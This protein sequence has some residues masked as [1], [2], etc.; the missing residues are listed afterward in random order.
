MKL[1]IAWIFDH[2]GIDWRSID[3][4]S[5]IEKFNATT[6]EIE[7]IIPI[8]LP[9]SEVFCGRVQ[10]IKAES[11]IVCY[12]PEIDQEIMLPLRPDVRHEQWFLVRRT[13][14]GFAWASGNDFF[15]AKDFLI[16]AV[17][18]SKD[19]ERGG[20]RAL[21]EDT[22]Y[23][24]EVGNTSLTNRSDMW[25]HRGFAREIG[26]ILG[27]PLI[28]LD[29]LVAKVPLVQASPSFSVITPDIQTNQCSRLA[30]LAIKSIV[31]QPTAIWM[32]LCLLRLD[33]R[34]HNAIVDMTNYVMF[35]LGHPMH[36]FDAAKISDA[37]LNVR[38]AHVG[39]SLRILDGQLIQLDE[40]DLVVADDKKILSLAGII[41]GLET[42]ISETTKSIVL[43]AACFDAATI[44][45]SSA[46]HKKRTESSLRFEKTLDPH[47]VVQAIQRFVALM[48]KVGLS[49]DGELAIM[50][51]GQLPEPLYLEITHAVIE[52]SLG[53]S[54]SAAFVRATFKA[55]ECEVKVLDDDALLPVYRVL[56][57]SFRATKDLI[58]TADLI[59]EVSR[60]YGYDAIHAVLPKI[61][62][63]VQDGRYLRMVRSI[64]RLL[65]HGLHMRELQSYAFFD[66]QFLRVI[67]FEPMNTVAVQQP[68]SEH[69][70]RLVTSLVPHLLHAV[71]QGNADHETLRF[72][73]WNR[74][75]HYE[76]EL[77][78]RPALSGI[79]FQK[80]IPLDFYA[81]KAL[82]QPLFNMIDVQVEWR[83][84]ETPLWPWLAPYQS[85]RLYAAGQEI[86]YAGMVDEM[87]FRP[88]G[89]GQ[90]FVFE[91]DVD[92]FCALTGN[93]KQFVPLARYP[94][95]TRDISMIMPLTVTT[96]EIES[97]IRLL[98][99]RIVEVL[100]VDFYQQESW[101]D[102]RSFT[103]RVIMK[104]KNAT[105]TAAEIDQL[106]ELVVAALVS[107]GAVI[108]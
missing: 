75:W 59:E 79:F 37:S 101:K 47:A 22:D 66:E 25:G 74:V 34:V 12:V 56:I 45:K 21:C 16:P 39:E 57:P 103:V 48:P 24:I 29:E 52:K 26:A 67:N 20:W 64:K 46:R 42:G 41:G 38:L 83:Q 96:H 1:S 106:Y 28:A 84:L 89:D 81:I 5:L 85:A 76:Q 11:L 94:M 82:L 91:L 35:D 3:L 100:L 102:R 60:F 51:V 65:A 77:T 50:V 78:E 30:T 98:D 95:V 23:L 19:E 69:W 80:K 36:A 44:R 68:I 9:L 8:T 55:L 6:A 90:A 18:V 49:Y 15:C 58:A 105:L 99:E 108:R 93:I 71:M 88:I 13:Q 70:R 63:H 73:E 97:A 7:S 27:K 40:G 86:G 53:T 107:H 31:Y 62:A 17:A 14:D 4:T 10:A 2:L 32:A 87:F 72:F 104:D 43:E 61:A 54:V 33:C 92:K